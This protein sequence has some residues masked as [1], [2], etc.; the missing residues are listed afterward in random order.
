MQTD[1]FLQYVLVSFG[2]NEITVAQVI[3]F[4]L[5]LSLL[6]WI[7]HFLYRRI[8]PSVFRKRNIETKARQRLGRNISL[9]FVLLVI[10][11][12]IYMF[13]FNLELYAS[14]SFVLKLSNIFEAL[15]IL[16]IARLLDWLISRVMLHNYYANRD[17]ERKKAAESADPNNTDIDTSSEAKATRT[18]QYIVYII[19]ALFIIRSFNLENSFF[20]STQ[21]HTID[22]SLPN[23]LTAILIL[24]LARLFSW[25]LIQ[26]ILYSYYK[27]KNINV[28]SQYAINQLL[29][30]VIYVIAILVAI[31]QLG[32]EMKL[33]WGGAAALLVGVGL[34]LQQTFNDLI[35][36]IILLFERTVEIED[37]VD[38]NGL[39]G[40]VKKIGLR[41][42]L[43]ET[44]DNITV[45]VPN[46]KLIV[47]NVI[48][49]SHYDDKARFHLTVGV[50]YG[51]DTAL[52]KRCLLKVANENIYV[53]DY[54][55]PLVRFVDFGD[56]ALVFE[57][58]FWTRNFIV[59]EDIKSD[60]R[61][62]IDQIFREE[63]IT[64]PFP[65]RVV[66]S[67]KGDS[68]GD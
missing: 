24:F 38:M 55:T 15:L 22:L 47:D 8:L 46:S 7:W 12:G 58:H 9:I 42:S 57:L 36:G 67:M 32:I 3:G 43:V 41:T 39:V 17:A 20:F 5:L 48:N 26:L 66:W 54:P 2:K 16:Q 14:N 33:V 10:L 1:E 30:Y 4:S 6:Y 56:S 68:D 11:G 50:A 61:F 62:T 63:K 19:S 27:R 40:K 44:F 25:V 52:V 28:G 59:I 45:I 37:V 51:S 35:S 64:I 53:L 34:G 60:L 65:Q 18:I 21:G 13:R 49:W 29:K 23:I 31:D